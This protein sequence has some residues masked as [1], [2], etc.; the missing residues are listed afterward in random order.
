MFLERMTDPVLV[1]DVASGRFVEMNSA[2]VAI[3]GRDRSELVGLCPSDL[4]VVTD[5]AV[6]ADMDGDNEPRQVELVRP[7]GSR[8][9]VE[10]YT[11][12]PTESG[13]ETFVLVDISRR[14]AE[15]DERSRRLSLEVLVAERQR[16]A[17]D[18]HDGVVQD[19]IGT[20]LVL[21]GMTSGL[22]DDLRSRIEELIDVQ[23]R[24]VAMIRSL[25]MDLSQPLTPSASLETT[26]RGIVRQSVPSLGFVPEVTMTGLDGRMLDASLVGHIVLSL[27]EI[28][29]NVARHARATR[30]EVTVHLDDHV[31]IEVTDNGV[32]LDPSG[33]RGN[34]LVNLG[35]RARSLDGTFTIESSSGGVRACWQVPLSADAAPPS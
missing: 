35:E 28:L 10:L 22:P 1:T 16:L 33:R 9:T 17:R 7:D 4:F 26:L 32:G 14:R 13:Y 24:I 21:G 25:V 19:I 8:S 31:L 11:G 34:G 18:L 12:A 15:E 5:E 20:A 29:S 2:A 3:T 23:G 27:R 30:V 6:D